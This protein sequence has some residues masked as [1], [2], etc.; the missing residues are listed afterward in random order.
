MSQTAQPYEWHKQCL[1]EVGS[2]SDFTIYNLPWGLMHCPVREHVVISAIGQYAIDLDKLAGLGLFDDL[3][4]RSIFTSASVNPILALGRAGSDALSERIRQ[5]LTGEL[6]GWSNSFLLPLDIVRFL[7]PIQVGD[8]TDFYSS[9]EHATNVGK[10]FRSEEDALLPNWKH[11]PVGYHGRS[12]SI[13]TTGYPVKRP[14]G[15]IHV[16]GEVTF[17]RTRKLDFELELAFVIGKET[18]LGQSITTAGASEYIAGYV[19]MNDC[20]ARDIQAW[21]YRPLGPFLGKSFA[22]AISP[23][24]IR[25]SALE[26]FLVDGPTQDV[27]VLDY[28]KTSGK[29]HL[30]I[31]LEVNLRTGKGNEMQLCKGN[32][33]LLYWSP[34]QQLAHHTVNG[35]NVRVGDLMASGTISGKDADALGSLLERSFNGSQPIAIGDE[36]RTFL[37]DGDTVIMRGHAGSGPR[38][39][40]FGTLS[41]TMVP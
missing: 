39:V 34:V 10:L 28:L 32:S 5:V 31:E 9:V 19:L 6:E 1:V 23:W 21:E 24:V 41:N 33:C 20:S 16:D 36:Q 27:E 11:L 14:S 7:M 38:R 40:G 25:A 18:A 12:S 26:P 13:V 30:D 15:Q 8:Y 4:D 3:V 17:S 29:H 35:C 2:E 22:T 37:E